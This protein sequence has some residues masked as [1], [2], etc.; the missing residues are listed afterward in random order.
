MGRRD[1][2]LGIGAVDAGQADLEIGGDAEPAGRARADPTVAVTL[3]SAG[4]LSLSCWPATLSAP[5]K[6]AE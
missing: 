2:P 6:Q 5:M 3:V 1:Q 4:T